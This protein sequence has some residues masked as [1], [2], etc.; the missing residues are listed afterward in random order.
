M[1]GNFKSND[2]PE[3]SEWRRT[4]PQGLAKS[5]GGKSEIAPRA[6]LCEKWRRGLKI[7]EETVKNRPLRGIYT[8]G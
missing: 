2:S 6:N 8:Q 4:F 5:D 1:R 3:I 7:E